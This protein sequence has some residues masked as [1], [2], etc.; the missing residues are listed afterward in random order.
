MMREHKQQVTIVRKSESSK[1]ESDLWSVK[2]RSK[3]LIEQSE[4]KSY[5]IDIHKM[6]L[7]LPLKKW[8]A[9]KKSKVY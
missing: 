4:K 2:F 3:E 9:K 6:P 1:K 5:G 7:H 8:R